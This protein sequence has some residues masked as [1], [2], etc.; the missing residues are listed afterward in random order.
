MVRCLLHSPSTHYC[1]LEGRRLSVLPSLRSLGPCPASP[2]A[3]PRRRAA[4]APLPALPPPGHQFST[5]AD[6]LPAI[7]GLPDG[8]AH[9]PLALGP[10]DVHIWWL[11]HPAA[12][13]PLLAGLHPALAALMPPEE[14]AECAAASDVAAGELRLLAR[15][16][17]RSV[18]SRYLQPSSGAAHGMEPSLIHPGALVFERNAHGKP[19]LVVPVAAAVRLR[20]N[21]T[22]TPGLVGVAVTAGAAVGLDAESTARRTRGEPLRLAR[23]RFAAP[24][25]AALEAAGD[26]AARA[27]L[28]LRLWTLKEAYVKAVGRGIAAPPGL[29]GFAFRLREAEGALDFESFTDAGGGPPGWHFALI[30][31]GDGHLAALCCEAPGGAAPRITAFLADTQAPDRG[32]VA[33]APRILAAGPTPAARAA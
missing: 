2:A 18:L 11:R 8:P 14:A 17:S 3:P 24:E 9:E 20:F 31:P 10:G 13:E 12:A 27:A 29:R 16:F 25:V 7:F 26:P 22:H 5:A 6:S 23:R 4:P 32:A 33:V 30:D 21:L 19:E 28:F 15:A 1:E